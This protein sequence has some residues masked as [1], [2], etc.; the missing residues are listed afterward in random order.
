MISKYLDK[1]LIL[2]LFLILATAPTQY[3]FNVG[4]AHLSLA[5]PLIWFGGLLF[6][7]SVITNTLFSK[8]TCITSTKRLFAGLK[9][10]LPL[11]ENILFV[12][13]IA[14]SVFNAENK[15][16][17][18]KELIQVVEYV[19]VAFLLFSKIKFDDK[20]LAKAT[21]LFLGIV[22]FVVLL[23]V[24]QYFDSSVVI[25]KVK[26]TFGNRNTYGGFLAVTLPLI[27]SIVLQSGKR[28]MKIWGFLILAAAGLTVLSGGA[29]AGLLIAGSLVCVFVS[30]RAFLIWTT[31]IALAVIFVLPR[32]PRDNVEVLKQSISIFDE[33]GQVEPR[34]TEWQA[35][36]QMWNEQPL[37]GVGLGNYQ[38][39]IGT[40]YGFLA[41]KE[42]PKEQ[43]HN[44]LFLVFASSTGLIGLIGLLT[45]LTLWFQRT[46]VSYFSCKSESDASVTDYQKILALGA[47]G[48]IAAFCITSIWTALLVRGVFLLFVIIVAV[49]AGYAKLH[50][51]STSA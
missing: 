33:N 7:I 46:T 39:Q 2:I 37:L 35:S 42:G 22:S 25:M 32:L 36:V 30:R 31:V 8:D 51:K 5:D 44:N 12:T 49:A 18:V 48:A 28:W 1:G 40:N 14:V 17:T 41:I 3:S 20:A 15:T 16:E 6:G 4:N 50:S 21:V 11:P 29:F 24:I 10:I 38:S 23:A 47:M 13:L 19:I 43:D 26:G 34:Y 45:M 27:L 9:E